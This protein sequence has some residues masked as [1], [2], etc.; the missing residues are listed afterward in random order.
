MNYPMSACI[1]TQATLN[2]MAGGMLLTAMNIQI[3]SPYVNTTVMRE[4][5]LPAQHQ[6]QQHQSQQHQS[7][8]H[9]SQ[10]RQNQQQHQN[11]QELQPQ[12]TPLRSFY[13]GLTALKS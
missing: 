10:Q 1:S 13:I 8:Q 2:H 6:N 7:Q 9:Q 5:L 4:Q 3:T 11:P 12:H